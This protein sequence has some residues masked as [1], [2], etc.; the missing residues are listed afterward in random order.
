MRLITRTGASPSSTSLTTVKAHFR[1]DA[2]YTDAHVTYDASTAATMAETPAA[3]AQNA[4]RSKVSTATPSTAHHSK[5]PVP[6]AA[7][8]AV[9]GTV[10]V[11]D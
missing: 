10:P 7:P 6:P 9:Q 8:A 11:P 5:A 3:M 1:S 4:N 2:A